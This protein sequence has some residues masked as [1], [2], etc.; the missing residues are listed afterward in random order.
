MAAPDAPGPTAS[1]RCREPSFAVSV[2]TAS[3]RAAVSAPGQSSP[4]GSRSVSPALMASVI[5]F[6]NRLRNTPRAPVGRLPAH[7]CKILPDVVLQQAPQQRV[8]HGAVDGRLNR[9][10]INAAGPL[11]Q[12]SANAAATTGSSGAGQFG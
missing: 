4:S 12:A 8:A 10:G 3:P 11:L 1:R 7:G 5:R 2:R 6:L 9:A